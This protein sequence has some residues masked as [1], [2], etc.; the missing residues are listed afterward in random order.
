MAK[1]KFIDGLESLFG[2]STMEEKLQDNPLLSE[3]KETGSPTI[4]EKEHSRPAASPRRRSGKSFTSDLDSLFEEALQDSLQERLEEKDAPK[5]EVK[6]AKPRR[7]MRKK[8]PVMGLD[9]LIRRTSDLSQEELMT[10]SFQKRVTFVYDREKVEQI[11]AIA[12]EKN[13]YMKD[14]IG[15]AVSAWLE[16][17][18]T[19]HGEIL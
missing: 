7:V 10:T 4:K 11:K 16:E 15:K 8:R 17:Y 18:E 6:I 5:V 19:Q 2:V 13:M 9:V 12:R 3:A 14:I 1:K